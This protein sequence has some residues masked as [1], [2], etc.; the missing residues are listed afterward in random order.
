MSLSAFRSL[1]SAYAAALRAQT[2]LAGVTVETRGERA[3]SAAVDRVI[4]VQLIGTEPLPGPLGCRD[5]A[6]VLSLQLG[7]RPTASRPDAEAAAD[8]L[9]Q[10]VWAA[11]AGINLP[12][13]I[14]Q[15]AEPRIDFVADQLDHAYSG[16]TVRF[17]VTHRT[18]AN[19]LQPWSA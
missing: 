12:D 8:D 1:Q 19:T 15:H 14:D 13:V 6:T 7:A 16:A 11:M 3:Q 2:A 18:Q 5:W 4:L 17:V 9:L 10:A